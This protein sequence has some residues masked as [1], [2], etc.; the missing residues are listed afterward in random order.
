MLA[1]RVFLIP[2]HWRS[3]L[4]QNSSCPGPTIRLFAKGWLDRASR[5]WILAAFWQSSTRQ[6]PLRLK[7]CAGIVTPSPALRKGA[8]ISGHGAGL[9]SERAVNAYLAAG[10][11]N[12]H[13][14]VARAEARR[15]AELG[16]VALIREGASCSDDERSTAS[17][18]ARYPC[19]HHLCTHASRTARSWPDCSKQGAR[20]YRHAHTIGV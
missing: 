6:M 20:E 14:L 13:E 17:K 16:L 19:A 9:P 7:R 1:A 10:V 2:A 4:L 5:T 11:T 15:Q 8:V 3:V 12:N 18:P